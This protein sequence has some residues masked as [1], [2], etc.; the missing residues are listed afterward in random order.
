VENATLQAVQTFFHPD[1]T[2]GSGVSPDH[3][4]ELFS[5]R[6]LAGF[7]AGRE[8][9]R[10]RLSPCPEG[11]S[12]VNVTLLNISQNPSLDGIIQGY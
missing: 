7:T 4:P 2:V 10:A 8:L 12:I 5:A 3:A 1:C 6:A 11:C 9:R